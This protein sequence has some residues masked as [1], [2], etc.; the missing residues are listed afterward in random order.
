MSYAISAKRD[1]GNLLAY[2]SQPER[3]GETI[4]SWITQGS[5]QDLVDAFANFEPEVRELLEVR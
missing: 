5:K 4:E 1:I 2:V 3:A